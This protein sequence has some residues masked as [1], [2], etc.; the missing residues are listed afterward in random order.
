[1]TVISTEIFAF[2]VTVTSVQDA[3]LQ[4]QFNMFAVDRPVFSTVH[5]S[6]YLWTLASLKIGSFFSSKQMV[7][8]KL[9]I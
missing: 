7:N 5:A 8:I 9:L 4:Y 6:I 3:I 1:M 2:S